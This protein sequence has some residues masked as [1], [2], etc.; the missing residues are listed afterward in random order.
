MQLSRP[1]E[2]LNDV[3]GFDSRISIRAQE[4][5]RVVVDQVED[6]DVMAAG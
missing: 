2:A 1:V 6:L 5:A 4:Q 3:F